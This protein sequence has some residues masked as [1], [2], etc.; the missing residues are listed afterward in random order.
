M[1]QTTSY[2]SQR[3]ERP[4]ATKEAREQQIQAKAMRLAEEK[5]DNGT[6]SSSLIIWILNQG[7]EKEK[8][9]K[10]EAEA[11]IALKQAK[12]EAI[13]SASEIK[14]LFEDAMTMFKRY[15]GDDEDASDL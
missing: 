13:K 12:V 15:H 2:A 7:T 3:R 14:D 9:A 4:A 8:L 1:K 6:A 11:D 5:L 10:K